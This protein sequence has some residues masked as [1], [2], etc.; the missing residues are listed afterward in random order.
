MSS[1][2]SCPATPPSTSTRRT[3]AAAAPRAGDD[4]FEIIVNGPARPGTQPDPEEMALCRQITFDTLEA[5][6]LTFAE[7]PTTEALTTPE[8]FHRMFPGSDGSLYGLSPHGLTAAFRRPRART[9]MPGLYLC[10][11]GRASGGGDPDGQPVRSARGRGDAAGPRFD[12][13]VPPGGYGWW[14]CDGV[15]ADGER[16]ISVIAFIGSVFSPWY[17]WSGRGDPDD[18]VC[19][20]VLMSGP[21]GRWTMTDRGR[22]ALR[23][24][25]DAIR[26]GP[27]GLAWKDGALHIDLDEA[28]TPHGTRI[29]GTVV[30]RPRGVTGVEVPL[31]A[32][33][34]HVWRPLAPASDIEVRID[35]PGWSW[36]GHGYLDSNFG[37][38]ALEDDFRYWHWGRFPVPDG[39]VIFYECELFDG[40]ETRVALHFDDS[41]DVRPVEAPPLAPFA[42]SAWGLRRETRCDAGHAPRAVRSMISSPFYQRAVVETV[43]GGHRTQGVW[44][45]LDGPKFAAWW[46]KPLLA[47]KVPRKPG[48][49]FAE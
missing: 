38:N 43:I 35:R 4:R 49:R 24:T 25:E 2:G 1:G 11:G 3:G 29:R 40:S 15:S 8:D 32:D 45:A 23:Q 48:W 13:A 34:S 22:A 5:M 12:V 16:S 39:R 47:L 18:H 6:G 46:M 21:G 36:D 7:R 20:N 27:S 33:G 28:A 31:K 17:G 30:I 42:R 41:G 14:Y 44:E 37:T 10:G 19:V 9:E 26:I